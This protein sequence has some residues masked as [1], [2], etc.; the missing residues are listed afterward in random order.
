MLRSSI[1]HFVATRYSSKFAAAVTK[2]A[3]VCLLS[4]KMSSLAPFSTSVPKK[5]QEGSCRNNNNN[6]KSFSDGQQTSDS[7]GSCKKE[8]LARREKEHCGCK[9]NTRSE[10]NNKGRGGTSRRSGHG[11]GGGGAGSKN[12]SSG[13]FDENCGGLEEGKGGGGMGRRPGHGQSRADSKK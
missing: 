10:D 9:D 8:T 7:L 1:H 11:R 12:V 13:T 3:A 2:P 5:C 6:N 4:E